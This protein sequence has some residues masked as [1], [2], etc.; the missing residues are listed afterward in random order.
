[1][2][3][4][5]LPE[6]IYGI[7]AERFSRGRLNVEVVSQMLNAG[8][9]VVQYREKHTQKTFRQMF[10][11]LEVIR[12]LTRRHHALL[13]VNDYIDLALAVDADGVHTGQDD[14]PPQAVREQI[15]PDKILGISTHSPE[16]ALAALKAG[17]DYIGVGPIFATQT[18]EDVCEPVGLEYLSFVVENIPLPFV[19]IGG[20]KEHNIEAVLERGARR[21]ALVTEIV[22]A[23][24]IVQKINNLQAVMKRYL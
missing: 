14:L 16:Q 12:Q 11:E 2:A 17:A 23:E 18:K 20:I 6:G 15:G 8:V 13:I 19:A 9:K 10:Q 21:V 7:T 1:M 4:Y 3:K 22:G 24:D 5:S